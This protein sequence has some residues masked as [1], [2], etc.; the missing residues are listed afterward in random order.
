[1]E[2]LKL[3][4][5]AILQKNKDKF[6]NQLKKLQQQLAEDKKIQ[7]EQLEQEMILANE[8]VDKQIKIDFDIQKQKYEN[9]SRNDV[10]VAKQNL[11]LSL[12]DD[13]AVEMTNWSRQKT[14]LFFNQIINQL[15]KGEYEVV[16]GEL[17]PQIENLPNGFVVSSKTVPNEAGFLFETASISYNFLYRSILKDLQQQYLG[18]LMQLL[19]QN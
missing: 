9:L 15:P 17:T 2:D 7:I 5:H 3:F 11:L 19:N 1:M 16:F 13:A 8:K 6:S 18:D 10:L 4:T 14:E 12:F